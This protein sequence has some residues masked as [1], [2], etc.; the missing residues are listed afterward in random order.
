M[1]TDHPSG[2]DIEA[3]IHAFIIGIPRRRGVDIPPSD[4][5]LSDGH[6]ALACYNTPMMTGRTAPYGTDSISHSRF[7]FDRRDHQLLA[8]VHEVQG[9]EVRPAHARKSLYPHFHPNGI[10]EMA[11]SRGIRVAHAVVRLL[12]SLEAGEMEDRLVALRTLREEVLTT[13]E[14]P[15]PRN[16]ARVLIEIMKDLVR[17]HGNERRQLELAHDFRTAASGRPRT[18]RRLMRRYHLLE[19]PEEWNQVAFDDHVHDANTKGRKS[20]THLIMDAWVKGI[21]RL[22]V[23]FYN[24]ITPGSATELMEAAR[25]MEMD[26][27]I[28][29]EFSARMR[30]KYAQLIWVPRGFADSQAYLC[31]LAE[32]PVMTLMAQG[33]E[34]SEYEQRH[35]LALLDR[36]NDD[37]RHKLEET[38]G[39]ELDPLDSAAFLTFVGGGQASLVHLGRFI[40][41]RMLPA[42]RQRAAELQERKD[43]V[44]P[45]QREA[46]R[47]ILAAMDAL[48][49]DDIIETYLG[50][51]QNPDL[52]DPAVP[53]DD[54]DLPEML[55]LSPYGL[56]QLLADIHSG[57]RITLNL[58]NLDTADVLELLYDCEGAVTRLEIFNLKDYVAGKTDY[59]AEICDLQA[60]LNEG[61]AIA[62]KRI[63]RTVIEHLSDSGRSDALDR[64]EKLTSIL[65]DI[66]L[67]KSMYKGAPIKARIGSDSTGQSRRFH[68]M[69]LAVQ[70][71]LPVRTQGEVRR[72]PRLV[73][74]M[75]MAVF[76]RV[77]FIPQDGINPF[78]RRLCRV[79]V[80][81][82]GLRHLCRKK[83]V[84]F[85]VQEDTAR[86]ENPG[87]IVT[88]GGFHA[89]YSNRLVS[90]ETATGRT[91]RRGGG[92]YLRTHLKNGGKVA[93]GFIPAFATFFFTYDWW[94]LAYLGA[95]IWFSITGL[96][97]IL[98][99]VLGGGGIRR[100]PL[101]RW[102]DYVS[103][104]RLTDSLLY[105]GFSVPLLDL[106]VKNGVLAQGFGITTATHPVAL[107]AIMAVANGTYISSHNI[108]RGFPRGPIYANFFRSILSIPLAV[109]FNMAFGGLL[110][111]SGAAAV[112]D[113]LQKWAAVISK[114][115]SDCV[116]GIIEG[117]SDRFQNIR[118]R[119]RDYRSR[120]K[121]LFDVYAELEL[122]FPEEKVFQLLRTPRKV[123]MSHNA[124]AIELEKILIINALDLLYF[125]MY[126]P[127]SRGALRRLLREMDPEERQIFLRTQTILQRHKEIS[128]MFI[129]GVVGR[130]FMK[131]L[132]FYLDRSGEYLR[133]IQ[134]MA[135]AAEKGARPPKDAKGG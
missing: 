6:L 30:N 129:D 8:I 20:S 73:V 102:N 125:W 107:Y 49:P 57:Y 66:A 51:E 111:L 90:G 96:R 33:R 24:Y 28:G 34:V 97:N 15:M 3:R 99:S 101:L 32:E 16:T 103:W 42:M 13:A 52:P 131:A 135:G 56:I 46:D 84:D 69:G 67:F 134:K 110:G 80:R 5:H 21:R 12:D 48:E 88:L 108:F 2:G 95:P 54:P 118:R 25:I 50:P 29:I 41:N 76:P 106:V 120:L 11:E 93:A 14:G 44:D 61:N 116:A 81:V 74:P 4:I 109:A 47:Q 119:Y 75:V 82:A 26:V 58:S 77:T 122:L 112:D 7:F 128:Q 35:I 100:S 17:F 59:L 38:F 39:I 130:N 63:I 79:I 40:L 132:A 19:M 31:F 104:Q 91:G 114:L 68:G 45:A 105:T 53:R 9:G 117:A 86:M 127:R 71:T 36:F 10:K 113:I 87:N 115:A 126:Q 62:L 98:Q 23:I 72:P 121:Q 123:R 94:V 85:Q 78:L 55:R 18:I 22:R 70:E 92:G 65:H 124:E 27:R 89:H 1:A 64:I 83:R 133:D 37:H 43:S 60:A